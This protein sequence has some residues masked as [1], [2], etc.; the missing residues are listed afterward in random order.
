LAFHRTLNDEVDGL[1]RDIVAIA[2]SLLPE[3]PPFRVI[4]WYWYGFMSPPKRAQYYQQFGNNFVDTNAFP[5][6]KFFS[7]NLIVAAVRKFSTKMLVPN[8]STILQ[9]NT[10]W[11]KLCNVRSKVFFA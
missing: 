11:K 7:P 3:Y 2:N 9:N 1:R 10:G 4:A 5:D 8:F 6:T